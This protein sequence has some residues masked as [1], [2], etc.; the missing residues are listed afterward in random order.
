MKKTYVNPEMTSILL[1]EEDVI[2]TSDFSFN[3]DIVD[4]NPQENW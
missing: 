3:D 2:R 4:E 1:D